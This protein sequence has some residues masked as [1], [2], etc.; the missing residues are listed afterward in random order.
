MNCGLQFGQVVAWC[1][2]KSTWQQSSSASDRACHQVASDVNTRGAREKRGGVRME[3][4]RGGA[5]RCNWSVEWSMR[6]K[7][8]TTFEAYYVWSQE[9]DAASRGSPPPPMFSFSPHRSR[10]FSVAFLAAIKRQ[11]KNYAVTPLWLP[12]NNPLLL[13]CASFILKT[14]KFSFS[15]IFNFIFEAWQ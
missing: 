3:R 1:S 9:M 13:L 7:E 10:L 2:H 12:D 4:W 5:R 6:I 15:K 8:K 14:S 11:N